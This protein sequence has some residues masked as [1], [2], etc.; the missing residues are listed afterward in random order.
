[1]CVRLC[2]FRR[3]FGTGKI[4]QIYQILRIDSNGK[5]SNRCEKRSSNLKSYHTKIHILYINIMPKIVCLL[6]TR[7]IQYIFVD[8][9][10]R[11]LC[12]FDSVPEN[13][14]INVHSNGKCDHEMKKNKKNTK[15]YLLS[16][17]IFFFVLFFVLWNKETM[18][19]RKQSKIYK[20]IWKWRR[21][22]KRTNNL[23]N[24]SNCD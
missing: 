17:H 10:N 19:K 11:T 3:Y 8:I 5:G 4:Y 13:R 2:A 7:P 24:S 1:M 12:E 20:S 9:I 16:R 14:I 6:P 23:K 22:K 15:N 21:R 18:L